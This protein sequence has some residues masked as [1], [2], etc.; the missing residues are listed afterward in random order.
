MFQNGTKCNIP[1]T[2]RPLHI[3]SKALSTALGWHEVE[4]I[5][6]KLRHLALHKYFSAPPSFLVAIYTRVRIAAKSL[7]QKLKASYHTARSEV[8]N[9]RN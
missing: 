3:S 8:L 1:G 4:L 2:S 5:L 6:V 7:S 9:T